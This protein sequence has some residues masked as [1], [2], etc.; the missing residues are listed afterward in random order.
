MGDLPSLSRSAGDLVPPG[1]WSPGEGPA[2]ICWDWMVS[3]QMFLST[4][5]QEAGSSA[6]STN[7]IRK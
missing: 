3:H 7:L 2:P 5:I 4:D 6:P 1:T